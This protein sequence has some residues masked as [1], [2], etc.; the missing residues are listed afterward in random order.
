MYSL[1]FSSK[2]KV[3]LATKGKNLVK[4][5]IIDY[6]SFTTIILFEQAVFN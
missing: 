3:D 5:T 6:L 2:E 4:S 1:T